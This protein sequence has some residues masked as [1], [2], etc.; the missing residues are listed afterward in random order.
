MVLFF[1]LLPFGLA[2]AADQSGFNQFLY[3]PLP[4]PQ[5]LYCPTAYCDLKEMLLYITASFLRIIPI[6]AVLFIIVGGYQIMMSSGNE[7]MLLRGKRTVTWAI[8]GLVVA[9]LSFSIVAI[10]ANLVGAKIQ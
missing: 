8:L 6:A 1:L 9:L 7:E 2:R 10:V 3:N 4:S 5:Q